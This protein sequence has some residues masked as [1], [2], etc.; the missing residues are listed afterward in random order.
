MTINIT[1]NTPIQEDEIITL[2]SANKWSSANK[3]KTLLAALRDS[4]TLVVARVDT[5]LVGITNAISD[6]HLVV[7]YPHML[8][9]PEFQG[10]GIGK[11]MME[12]MQGVYGGFH[13]QMLTADGEA[14]SFYKKLGFSKAGQTESMWIYD[15]DDH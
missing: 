9:L 12:A 13:Q 8:V 11:K 4:H 15:G 14:I 1:L 3:P 5:Q 2:Y 10:Q 6:G 7:Y